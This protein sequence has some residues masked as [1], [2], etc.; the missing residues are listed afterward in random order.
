MQSGG[1]KVFSPR[2]DLTP[3]DALV[4]GTAFEEATTAI[5]VLE[6]GQGGPGRISAEMVSTLDNFIQALL[7]N[8]RVFIS[9]GPWV[10]GGK[11]ISGG[12]RYRGGKA[13]EKLLGDAGFVTVL[14]A[15]FPDPEAL[16]Q[17]IDEILKPVDY[18][19]TNWYVISCA[20]P[21]AMSTM[22]QEMVSLDAF[23]LED[24]IDQ[25]GVEKFKP[26]FPGENLYLGLRQRRLSMPRITQTMSDVVGLRIRT[27]IRSKMEKL[28]VFV[29]QGAPPVPEM[30]P[31]YVSRILRDCATG[32]DF[33]PALLEIRNSAAMRRLRSWM[34]VCSEQLRSQD[35]EVRAKAAAA[36]QKFLN[37]PL[38]QAIDATE[39]GK[40]V[41]NVA[42]DA[43]HGDALGIL[44]EIAGPVISYFLSAPFRGLREFGGSKAEPAR[45][46]AFL[47]GTF[48]DKFTRSEMN[49]ISDWLKLPANLKD[50]AADDA[51]LTVGA[52]RIYVDRDPLARS[53]LIST[54]D[55]VV[56]SDMLDD[57]KAMQAKARPATSPDAPGP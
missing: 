24:A 30:P 17:R 54:R 34:K 4:S 23:Y 13:G 28:N 10:D 25:G 2:M 19:K 55:P 51:G 41:L 20:Y 7:F 48:G 18:R 46:D 21:K 45:L 32:S 9:F 8:E 22:N 15:K 56:A 31:I 29:S 42:I 40:S 36:W 39:A 37:F 16:R 5:G 47:S 14:P 52:G 53:Y 1:F 11:I 38:E 49:M 12:V 35:L 44:G 50:W 6:G 57:F 43:I 33:I 26:V 27:A 3:L